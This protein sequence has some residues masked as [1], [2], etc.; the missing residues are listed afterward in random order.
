MNLTVA[1][2]G[3]HTSPASDTLMRRTSPS[4]RLPLFAVFLS[5]SV[6]SLLPL[7]VYGC[8][9]KKERIFRKSKILMDTLVTISVVARSPSEADKAVDAAFLEIERLEK[10]GNFYSADSELSRVNR[11]AGISPVTVSPD[12]IDL[13]TK[14]LV[15]SRK[16][17][18]AFD[19]TIGPVISLYDFRA[20]KIPDPEAIRKS[21]PLVGYRKI[22]VD[23]T[24]STIFLTEKGMSIDLGGIMKGYAAEKATEV[25]RSQG[26]RA[27]IVSV[28][29]DVR[30]FGAK[31]DG[32]PW[33]VGIRH[34]RG[35]SEEDVIAV[36]PL[37]D[38]SISTSGD[39]ERFSLREGKRIHH[40]ISPQTG[41]PVSTCQSASVIA[42][43]GALADAYSTGVFLLGVERGLRLLETLGFE[44]VI[45]DDKGALHA[46]PGIR[47][48]LEIKTGS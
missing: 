14:A 15:V 20:R 2:R 39:Y 25:L 41:Y 34:P 21:L 28:A 45:V 35:R 23:D 26:I 46:T 9:S 37:T 18:G 6:I 44:G 42:P 8:A 40:L 36:L 22:R 48:V 32:S 5:L 24:A 11:D 10:M 4:L 3:E 7:V 13:V 16:T 12:L 33:K 47:R 19:P 30:A 17:D 27:G 1:A 31:P 29:G 43:S 38:L